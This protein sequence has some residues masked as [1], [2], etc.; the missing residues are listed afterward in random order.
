MIQ[1]PKP[2]QS[3][4]ELFP[5]LLLDWCNDNEG[6]LYDYK[7]GSN[8]KAHWKC[9]KC[10][11]ESY[12]TIY[13]ATTYKCKKCSIID[14]S[15]NK[16]I[17]GMSLAEAFPDVAKQW[18]P[19]NS[20]RPGDVTHC[21]DKRVLWVCEFGHEWEQSVANRTQN[22]ST[23]PK[24]ADKLR[25]QK[26]RLAD[27]TNSLLSLY[28][29][30]AKEIDLDKNNID[31]SKIKYGSHDVLWWKCPRGHSYQSMIAQR[32]TRRYGCPICSSYGTSL[33]EQ[34]VYRCLKRKFKQ[35]FNRD[36]TFGIELDI[37]I[38]DINIAIEYSGSNWHLGKEE[39]DSFK[40]EICKQNNIKLYTIIEES[41]S[42]EYKQINNCTFT[43]GGTNKEKPKE[44]LKIVKQILLDNGI[45]LILTKEETISIVKE[46]YEYRKGKPEI[47]ESIAEKRPDL[48]LEWDFEL[49]ETDPHYISCG[50]QYNAAW[51]CKDC[52]H[53]WRKEVY[54]RSEKNYKCPKCK[55]KK[56]LSLS[57]FF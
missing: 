52:G 24:C 38:K 51:K 18:S 45:N 15:K 47:G 31:T 25:G 22:K 19:K 46:A 54:Y 16:E 13:S 8:Y 28:P 20:M 42:K 41:G 37:Y 12:R 40:D 55:N 17:A 21:S 6:T 1:K 30:I 11:T 5:D 35:V 7:K 56:T 10:N 34:V 23:C 44:I 29:D 14:R 50:S 36:K 33:G 48:M 43:I 3:A 57:D 49:N 2:G 32:T 9:H 4:A 39:A 53:R 27:D 26:R